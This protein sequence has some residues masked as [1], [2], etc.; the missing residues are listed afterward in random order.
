MLP[1]I[2]LVTMAL[3]TLAAVSASLWWTLGRGSDDIQAG[4]YTIT[5]IL[6]PSAST[7]DLDPG[8]EIALTADGP[9]TVLVAGCDPVD[10]EVLERSKSSFELAALSAS[11]WSCADGDAGRFV[12]GLTGDE[13]ELSYST[14]GIVSWF[15]ADDELSSISGGGEAGEFQLTVG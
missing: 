11:D 6:A 9:V 15:F 14:D 1:S 8:I 12:A 3:V 2:S 7:P 4:T 5:E 10:F 13:L